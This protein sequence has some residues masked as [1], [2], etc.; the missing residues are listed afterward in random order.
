M[1]SH[2]KLKSGII[3]LLLTA[4]KDEACT[5]VKPQ[6]RNVN[7]GEAT[8][9]IFMGLVV[10]EAQLIVASCCA[11]PI[12]PLHMTVMEIL[13]LSCCQKWSGGLDWGFFFLGF[14]MSSN[15]EMGLGINERQSE[16]VG[17]F[18]CLNVN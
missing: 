7:L 4:Y 3:S 10:L 5:S 13:E 15:K 6:L 8:M 12:F 16:N 14:F 17:L 9:K 2:F 11:E 1:F 18:L